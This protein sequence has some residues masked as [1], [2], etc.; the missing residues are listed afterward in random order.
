[1][2]RVIKD[3]ASDD[4]WH[5]GIEDL[6]APP[7]DSARTAARGPFVINLRTSSA[8]IGSPPKGLLPINRLHVYELARSDDGRPQFQLRLGII[9]SELEA[10]ALLPMV[11]EHYPAAMK[12]TAD[13]DD[14]AATAS[15]GA[16]ANRPPHSRGSAW[17]P[18][19]V[20]SAV[21]RPPCVR[22]ASLRSCSAS[23]RFNYTE[24]KELPAMKPFKPGRVRIV[25]RD[26]RCRD[27]VS[28]RTCGTAGRFVGTNP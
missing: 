12:E 20:A 1:M 21:T 9:E 13:D 22:R 25:G 4:I 10:D 28:A 18:S 19:P 15:E 2:A 8:T 5:L 11:R 23:V 6:L 27:S 17:P 3:Q 14:R 7:R 26:C 24:A 16:E